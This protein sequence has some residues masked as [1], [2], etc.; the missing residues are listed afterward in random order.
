MQPVSPRASRF[1]VA[2]LAAAGLATFTGAPTARAQQPAAT[3]GGLEEVI[4]TAQKR[5]QNLQEIG[6]SLSAVSG[7]DLTDLG[8]VNA[9][10]ITKSMPAVVLTQPNG[11]SSFSLAIRGVVQN[12][13]ADHQ[14][15]PA[16]IYVDDVYVSQM[17]GLAF[18]TFDIDRVEVLRGPQG[19]L[20]GR[21]ATGGLAHFIS[22]RPTDEPSGYMDVTLGQRNLLRVEG[23]FGGAL[24]D[25]IDGRIAFQ[26]NH[27]DPLFKNVFGPASDAE[28]GNDWGL[29][30]QLLFKLPDS[31]QLLLLGRLSRTDV[32]AGSWEEYATKYIG[33]GVDVFV[34]PNEN[35]YG[36][37]AGCNA[38]GLPNSGPFVIRDSISGF[39]RLK[40][41]GLT[42]KYTRPFGNIALT[43]VGDFTSLRKDYQEDSDA[44]PVTLFQFFNGSKVNQESVEAR[45]NG[46][47]KKLNW[48]AGVYGLRIDGKYYEGWQGPSF[49]TAEEFD[50]PANPNGCP[51]PPPASCIYVPG[52][53]PYG[54]P[55]FW[56]DFVQAPAN[57]GRDAG[58]I[59]STQS[60]Y[61]LLTKSYAAFAQV[62]YRLSDLVG[63]TVGARVTSDKK[64]FQFT[65]FPYE[66]FPQSTTGNILKLTRLA[67]VSLTDYPNSRS[68]S[69]FSGK[70]ELDFHVAPDVLTYVSYNRGVKGGG[71]NAP[72]FPAFIV[73]VN[74]M[75]FKPETLTSY[76]VGVKS[77]FLDRK[78]RLNGA[79]YYYDYKDYQALVYVIGLL[80]QVVNADATHKGAELELEWAPTESWRF[81]AGVAY[82]DA[83]IKNVLGR[84]CTAAGERI[85]G[86]FVPGN[87]PRWTA[88]ALARYTFPVGSGR[89]ALQV[90][91]NY[92]SRFWF[93][94]TDLPVVEQSAFGVAN[95][96]ANYTPPSGKLEIG[97]SVENLADKHYGTMG[98][99]NTSI[100]GLAQVYP[101]MPRWF[102]AH[103]NYHF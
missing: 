72:L 46:G 86:D 40:G 68:D 66:F 90:D 97:V 43:V 48:T 31:A 76:E 57:A 8:V 99:D 35:F 91:G 62:E 70:A 51:N 64:D 84:C 14:E 93:N 19:T 89:L 98:F 71:Y 55:P 74:G 75:T 28:N 37:C 56:N 15:S 88:S 100:N 27:Y 79:A 103:I 82:V 12:D 39:T 7:S 61:E 95:M 23:A 52:A 44:S 87:A 49:F 20:F 80:Q 73:D 13:F 36:T 45:L 96:R 94:L 63:L 58:G 16:A 4:V 92:L 77:E 11:P 10:D 65:W 78:L 81:G 47:D 54:T 22:R 85:N 3:S 59:P 24:A 5:E 2:V 42:A 29:R 17:I 18:S 32:H 102:K 69:L 6:I 33:N 67:G 30:G 38:S 25:G 53:W 41:G 9:T 34:G 21:N 83:I 50:N 60:P 26:T 101:G 1:H